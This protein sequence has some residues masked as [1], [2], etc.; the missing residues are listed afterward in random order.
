MT[1]V[2]TGRW[3]QET[4][5]RTTSAPMRTCIQSLRYRPAHRSSRYTALHPSGRG[6]G[7]PCGRLHPIARQRD[8]T[9][10]MCKTSGRAPQRSATGVL[11]KLT[12][13][14]RNS[15][16]HALQA[17]SSVPGLCRTGARRERSQADTVRRDGPIEWIRRNCA[18]VSGPAR[19]W[20]FD[21]HRR[22]PS[23]EVGPNA[24]TRSRCHRPGLRARFSDYR[25]SGRGKP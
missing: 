4:I 23:A 19:Q 13:V 14:M 16:C 25:G 6:D 24:T 15:G 11:V 22:E 3:Q 20:P 2:R 17:E 8:L 12:P 5:P 10:P 9:S 21:R 1:L 7:G 18:G